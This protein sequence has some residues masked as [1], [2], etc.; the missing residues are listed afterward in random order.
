MRAYLSTL[1]LGMKLETQYR[2]AFLSGFVTQLFF[3]FILVFLY[4]ALY[5]GGSEQ[6]VSMV[7]IASYVWLQQA[8]F[9]MVLNN[10]SD[11]NQTIVTG[12]MAY[13]LCRPVSQ[14]GYWF[15]HTLSQRLTGSLM[16]ALPMLAVAA[17][18]PAGIGLAMP[19]SAPAMLLFLLSLTLGLLN[20]CAI[21]NICSAITLR[22]LDTRGISAMINLVQLTFSGNL[23]PLTLFPDAWQ[24]FLFYTPFAQMLDAPIRLY[25]GEYALVQAPLLLCVQLLW[26]C[27]LAALGAAMWKQNLRRIVV[28]GG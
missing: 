3:G 28:Q 15:M 25:T 19:T 5:Q 23:L 11:L 24:N 18:L 14:Y 7:N 4:R 16:R 1:K 17:L 20:A 9:R 8:F 13:Q 10:D 21:S 6:S 27:A 2:A 22:T 12:G 26:L